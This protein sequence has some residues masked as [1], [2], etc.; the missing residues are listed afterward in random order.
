MKVEELTVAFS[1]DGKEKV[2]EL[3]K[4]VLSQATSWATIAFLFQEIDTATGEWRAPKVSLRRYRKRAGRYVVDK[5]FT[6]S[7]GRQ[8]RALKDALESWLAGPLSPSSDVSTPDATPES[9]E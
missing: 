4:V 2:R 9:D 6:L 7:S 1:E 3:A 5:H 8:A